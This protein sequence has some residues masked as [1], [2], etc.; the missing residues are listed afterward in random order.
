MSVWN[1]FRKPAP[2]AVTE[3]SN[4]ADAPTAIAPYSRPVRWHDARPQ[5]A[6]SGNFRLNIERFSGTRWKWCV[7]TIKSSSGGV[8][9]IIGYDDTYEEARTHG[10]AALDWVAGHKGRPQ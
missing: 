5:Y 2:V 1:A 9:M 10:A 7:E 3:P 6:E 4:E 8:S